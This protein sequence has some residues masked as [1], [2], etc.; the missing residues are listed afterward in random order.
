[1]NDMAQDSP[2]GF[3]GLVS[4]ASTISAAPINQPIPKP[5]SAAPR[6]PA[7]SERRPEAPPKESGFWTGK[8]KSWAFVI[9]AAACAFAYLVSQ[10]NQTSYRPA[11]SAYTPPAPRTNPAPNPTPNPVPKQV[12]A[13]AP[14]GPVEMKI[15]PANQTEVVLSVGELKY[16]LAEK[17]R[18]DTMEK[19][20]SNRN[21]AHVRNFNARVDDYN[22]RCSTYRYRRPDMATATAE[23]EV[24]RLALQLQATDIVNAWR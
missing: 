14:S 5:D 23:V 18:L 13:P 10:E 3:A 19:V 16:C 22:S 12:P 9:G 15:P 20:A 11:P 4:L 8:R 6:P 24:M 21:Q 1:M 2:K 7:P 17:I